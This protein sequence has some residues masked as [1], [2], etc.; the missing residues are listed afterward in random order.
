MRARA[1]GRPGARPGALGR[2]RAAGAGR[3]RGARRAGWDSTSGRHR[4]GLRRG[5]SSRRG[6]VFWNGPMGAFELEPFAAGTRAVAE[7]VA[8]APGDDRGR[9]RR[10]GG[11]AGRVRARR[12]EVDWLSTGGGA[13]LELMEGQGAAGVVARRC[14][15]RV[16]QGGAPMAERTPLVAANWKMHKTV[17]ETEALPG[18]LPAAGPGRLGRAELVVCPPYPRWRRRSSAA[19]GAAVRVA[20]QNMHEEDEGA[21]TG[22]VS[23]PMLHRAGRGRRG[24][25]PLRAPRHCSARRTRPWRARCRRRSRP[26]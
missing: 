10:L 2:H 11:R 13:S 5:G 7:A 6:T 3:R 8:A 1:P 19:P 15:G 21:F 16:H 24:P 23:A 14:R 4:R 26:G 18:R 9:R 25:R 22:E 12:T 20:A 17:A